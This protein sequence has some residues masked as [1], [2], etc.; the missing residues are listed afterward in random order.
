MYLDLHKNN[1]LKVNIEKHKG[2][3]GSL[4]ASVCDTTTYYSDRM[5]EFV[6]HTPY[7]LKKTVDGDIS[8]IHQQLTVDDRTCIIW[9][10]DVADYTS[11]AELI[12]QNTAPGAKLMAYLFISPLKHTSDSFY[13]IRI[14]VPSQGATQHLFENMMVKVTIFFL[15]SSIIDSRTFGRWNCC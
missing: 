4:T 9:I 8:N 14:W 1:F 15:Y 3:K 2:Y 13:W 12:K 7:F 6:A 10:E 5:V 11:L